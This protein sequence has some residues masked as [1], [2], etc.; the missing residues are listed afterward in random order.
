MILDSG[1]V[2]MLDAGVGALMG[3]PVGAA[4]GVGFLFGAP[5]GA[6]LGS[7]V[8]VSAEKVLAENASFYGWPMNGAMNDPMIKKW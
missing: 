7:A 2:V 4:L 1:F 3:G 6:V 8:G 5:V